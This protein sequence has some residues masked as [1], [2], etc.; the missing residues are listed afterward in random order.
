MYRKILVA[1]DLSHAPC[2]VLVIRSPASEASPKAISLEAS[3]HLTQ[4]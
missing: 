4:I 3:V 1:V 2:S